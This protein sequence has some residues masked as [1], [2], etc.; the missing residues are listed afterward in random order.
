MIQ[1]SPT[2]I[3]EVKRLQKKQPQGVAR[4]PLRIAVIKRGCKGLSY[5][6]EFAERLQAEDLLF[7]CAENIQVVVAPESLVYLQDLTLDYTEDLMGGG[8]RFH[9]PR[10]T[11]TC[12]CG[13]SFAMDSLGSAGL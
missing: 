2:A 10:V 4:L 8:F 11:V 12:S 1:L 13:N 9:N 5:Q 6:L 3:G 7:D